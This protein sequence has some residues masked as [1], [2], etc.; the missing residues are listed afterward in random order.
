[1]KACRTTQEHNLDLSA[2]WQQLAFL[3]GSL[4]ENSYP[5]GLRWGS[6]ITQLPIFSSYYQQLH[7]TLSTSSTFLHC[8]K[9]HPP[10]LQSTVS[11]C[12]LVAFNH[13]YR[14]A[15]G[16]MPASPGPWVVLF[17]SPL[18]PYCFWQGSGS[19]AEAGTTPKFPR[20]S[21][22][23]QKSL[24]PDNPFVNILVANTRAAQGASS[25]CGHFVASLA[26]PWYAF[27]TLE[28]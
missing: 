15:Q 24:W 12:C 21:T 19:A 20:G 9:Q 1:M 8:S 22:A 7:Q 6:W 14:A 18:H 3:V 28:F 25:V 17:L 5:Q 11:H 26:I 27:V 16:F 23:A 2:G 4:D 10:L 13:W